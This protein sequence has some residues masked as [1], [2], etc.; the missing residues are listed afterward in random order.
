MDDYVCHHWGFVSIYR[1]FSYAIRLPSLT[2]VYVLIKFHATFHT[3]KKYHFEL[4]PKEFALLSA[5]LL[6]YAALVFLMDFLPHV[7]LIGKL[8]EW[9][10]SQ[11]E[12]QNFYF[13]T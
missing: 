3:H 6:D 2:I 1:P 8:E 11:G 9:N 13:I 4:N 5:P 7:N 12:V 10:L